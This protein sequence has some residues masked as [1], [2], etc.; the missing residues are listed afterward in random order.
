MKKTLPVLPIAIFC[1]LFTIT[2]IA[3]AQV[4]ATS[5]CV[6]TKVGNPASQPTLP[7]GCSGSGPS[8][9]G[10]GTNKYRFPLDAGVATGVTTEMA[11]YPGTYSFKGH[12]EHAGLDID[13][14]NGKRPPVY[15]VADGVVIETQGTEATCKG[16]EDGCTIRIKHSIGDGIVSLYTHTDPIISTKTSVKKG[17]KIGYV[18]DWL[19]ANI[20]HLHFELREDTVAQHNLNPRLYLPELQQFALLP[21]FKKPTLQAFSASRGILIEDAQPDTEWHLKFVNHPPCISRA[22]ICWAH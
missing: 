20:D 6:V 1:F 13:T 10:P 15:A 18:H 8:N 16:Q 12:I 7:A 4:S 17:E 14:P 9:G 11:V 22:L 2:T 19:V 21:D 5:K 3:F